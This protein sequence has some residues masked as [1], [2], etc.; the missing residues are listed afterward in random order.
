M[1]SVI[2]GGARE[3]PHPPAPSLLPD[4]PRPVPMPRCVR[5]NAKFKDL[6]R[7]VTRTSNRNQNSGRP[8]LK[9]MPCRKFVTW[10]DTRGISENGPRCYCDLPCRLLV[11]GKYGKDTPRGLHYV[12]SLGC[13][14]YFS[15]AKTNQDEQAVVTEELL[16][17]FMQL[18]IL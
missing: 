6:E 16:E 17:M 15:V 12:C 10:L 14:D 4:D 11:A 13:C 1:V 7:F 18:R 5:C 8:Y 2:A 9:C 3:P